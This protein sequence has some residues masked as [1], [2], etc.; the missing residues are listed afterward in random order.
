MKISFTP[1]FIRIVYFRLVYCNAHL[2]CN[3]VC[4]KQYADFFLLEYAGELCIIV[5]KGEEESYIDSHTHTDTTQNAHKH[6]HNHTRTRKNKCI[7]W[8]FFRV[9]SKASNFKLFSAVLS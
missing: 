3:C 5:L 2:L 6:T 9:H 7:Y 4:L 8:T 1:R